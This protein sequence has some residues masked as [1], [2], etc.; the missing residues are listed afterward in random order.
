VGCPWSAE[1]WRTS[2]SR[3]APSIASRYGN[4]FDQLPDPTTTITAITEIV[5]PGAVLAVRVPNGAFFRR[6]VEGIGKSPRPVADA[7]RATL[8]WNNLLGFPYLYG[9]SLPTLTALLG[10]FGFA[11]VHV[12]PDT[13]VRLSDAT[14]RVW[15]HAEERVAKLACRVAWTLAPRARAHELAP[16]LDVYF[17][18]TAT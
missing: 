3:R 8:A 15:A 1:R 7:L 16:W 14:T 4:T 2:P 17:R 12:E 10:R 6:A 18:R 13:L 11:T 5:R 9:Y